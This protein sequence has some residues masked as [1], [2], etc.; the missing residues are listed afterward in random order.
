MYKKY[1]KII[2]GSHAGLTQA[3]QKNCEINMRLKI[4]NFIEKT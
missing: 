2:S 3:H 4:A 1:F